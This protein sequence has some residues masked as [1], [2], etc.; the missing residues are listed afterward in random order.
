MNEVI[1]MITIPIGIVGGWV[2]YNYIQD[3]IDKRKGL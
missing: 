2:V 3:R 1:I